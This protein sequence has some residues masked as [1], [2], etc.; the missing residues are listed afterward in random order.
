[1]LPL[2]PATT[3][4]TPGFFIIYHDIDIVLKAK[5]SKVPVKWPFL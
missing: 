4:L 1:M 5:A 3:I 2:N